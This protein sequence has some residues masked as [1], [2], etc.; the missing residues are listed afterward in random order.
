MHTFT[1]RKI[2]AVE[3]VQQ[4][5]QLEINGTGQ[6]D[7]FEQSL[8]GSTYE[9]EFRQMLAYM[10]YVANNRSLPLTKFRDITPDKDPV[11]E[12]EF[13]SRHLRIYACRIPGGKLIILGGRKTGQKKDITRFRSLKK[14]YLQTC[15]KK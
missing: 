10:E 6:L 12:Y 9:G 4:F 7:A 14:Q 8:R 3:G 13:K 15:I 2:E 1:V 11:K 5:L